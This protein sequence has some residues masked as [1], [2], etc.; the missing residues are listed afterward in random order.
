MSINV[1]MMTSDDFYDLA[2]E[3]DTFLNTASIQ[4]S[5]LSWISSLR[6]GFPM[7]KTQQSF[8]ALGPWKL[9]NIFKNRHSLKSIERIQAFSA[10]KRDTAISEPK[11]KDLLAMLDF[12]DEKYHEFY[13]DV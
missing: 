7:I 12:L 8:N 1:V 11:K 3:C 5:T 2:N 4:I 6:D 13:E 9:H 10:S